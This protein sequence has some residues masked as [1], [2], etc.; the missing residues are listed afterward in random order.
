MCALIKDRKKQSV[1]I[2]LSSL[3]II[4][5]RKALKTET[6]KMPKT[7]PSCGENRGIYSLV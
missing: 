7:N 5:R 1:L 3:Q 4:H 2:N 6:E